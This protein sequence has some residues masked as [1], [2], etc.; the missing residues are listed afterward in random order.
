MLKLLKGCSGSINR[1]SVVI[2]PSEA[3]KAKPIWQMLPC[4]EL[5]V[6]TSTAMKRRDAVGAVAFWDG[7]RG[8]VMDEHSVFGRVS[9]LGAQARLSSAEL[10]GGD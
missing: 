9:T 10:A 5:A 1:P 3:A 6:S 7:L 8:D 4:W 2:V